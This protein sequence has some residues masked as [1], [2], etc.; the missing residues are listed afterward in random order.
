MCSYGEA[1]CE[2]PGYQVHVGTLY[3]FLFFFYVYIGHYLWKGVKKTIFKK[4]VLLFTGK[5]KVHKRQ[6]TFLICG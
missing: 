4:S 3:V 2:I 1:Y 5:K 6:K